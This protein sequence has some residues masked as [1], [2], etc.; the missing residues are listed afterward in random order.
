M[1]TIHHPANGEV[2]IQC[3]TR[4]EVNII[5]G[6]LAKVCDNQLA[7]ENEIFIFPDIVDYLEEDFFLPIFI[8]TDPRSF[9]IDLL[10]TI[11][12]CQSLSAEDLKRAGEA[13]EDVKNFSFNPN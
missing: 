1:K 12:K 9:I 3:E 5:L 7:L 13:L 8:P 6:V 2:F 11:Q 4:E 10:E